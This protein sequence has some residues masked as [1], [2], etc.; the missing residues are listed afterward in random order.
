V[1]DRCEG[2]LQ[3]HSVA[4]RSLIHYARAGRKE[5]NGEPAPRARPNGRRSASRIGNVM[6][7]GWSSR[8]LTA[9]LID[10]AA[11]AAVDRFG[12]AG[13]YLDASGKGRTET[14]CSSRLESGLQF[15]AT[16]PPAVQGYSSDCCCRQ[17]DRNRRVFFQF[18]AGVWGQLE[19]GAGAG[20][21]G[22]TKPSSKGI[23]RLKSRA[24]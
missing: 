2:T 18:K 10:S 16:A 14:A 23:F 20:L 4:F 13:S 6:R 9:I 1:S 8:A 21:A 3:A 24:D 5:K 19:A 22:P 12:W 7:A 11:I 15:K 17:Q